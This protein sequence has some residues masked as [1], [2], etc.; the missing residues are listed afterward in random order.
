MF[1]CIK[2]AFISFFT[3]Q[4][5]DLWVGKKIHPR[6]VEEKIH[7]E[8]HKNDFQAV[9]PVK[10]HPPVAK[11]SR[12]LIREFKNGELF[13]EDR[14]KDI[15]DEDFFLI[16]ADNYSN[17]TLLS[18]SLSQTQRDKIFFS[19]NLME[20]LS[21]ITEKMARMNRKIARYMEIYEEIYS[22]KDYEKMSLM[23]SRMENINIYIS[24][25]KKILKEIKNE[26]NFLN[27][28]EKISL[29]RQYALQS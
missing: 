23:T 22:S 19:K 13:A 27:H 28:V 6:Q 20:E 11:L 21:K 26:L 1:P 29:R 10:K 7:E 18:P 17:L 3:L 9:V 2:Y 4:H 16:Y 15:L 5:P 24:K 12:R 8:I 14:L 25:V